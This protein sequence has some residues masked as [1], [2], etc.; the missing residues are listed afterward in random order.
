[1]NRGEGG[2]SHRGNK[3]K[4]EEERV[5]KGE[6]LRQTKRWDTQRQTKYKRSLGLE[7]W[8]IISAGC[9]PPLC[10]WLWALARQMDGLFSHDSMT[11]I[12]YSLSREL[13]LTQGCG[14]RTRLWWLFDSC[15]TRLIKIHPERWVWS[16]I[17]MP[18]LIIIIIKLKMFI[19]YKV[20]IGNTSLKTLGL[21]RSQNFLMCPADS[22]LNKNSGKG[23]KW[24]SIES[25]I[26]TLNYDVLSSW[27]PLR[28]CSNSSTI[29]CNLTKWCS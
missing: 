24:S 12:P 10:N 20:N 17:V 22:F 11:L 27:F 15:P 26:I 16:A 28:G 21:H 13:H 25:N 23:F 18:Y 1:M 19:M 5:S 14:W 3:G 9:M 29:T 8:Y 6:H 2:R 4:E 7:G